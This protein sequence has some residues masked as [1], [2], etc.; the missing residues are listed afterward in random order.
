M[1]L[2]NS[3]ILLIVMAIFLLIS[4]GSVCAN[5]NV[6]EDISLADD[7]TDVV[8]ADGSATQKIDTK[9]DSKNVKINEKETQKIEVTVKDKE[10]KPINVSKE[11]FTVTKDK[12]NLNFT[13]SNNSITLSNKLAKGNHSLLITYLGNDVYNNSTK[14]IVL[15]I[16]GDY[17]I[18]SPSTVNV[19]QTQKVEVP[20]KLTNGVDETKDLSKNK[21][22]VK[23]TYKD[24]NQSKTINTSEL[25]YDKK[26]GKLMFNADL[27]DNIASYTM[28]LTYNNNGT[29]LLKSTTLKKV[30]SI[31]VT[32]IIS[33]NYYQDGNFTFKI[34]DYYTNETIANE[35]ITISGK[36]NGSAI[37]WDIKQ[38]G[39][40]ISVNTAKKLTADSKGIVT[41]KNANFYPNLIL[42][43]TDIYAPVGEY[44]LT[45]SGSDMTC[46]EEVKITIKKVT[47]KISIETF[48]EYYGTSKKIKIV[49][50]NS[51]T[52]KPLSGVTVFFNV[53]DSKGKE[54]VYS[55][56]DSNNTT[57]KVNKI[58]TN[59][60]GAVE[61]PANNLAVGKYSVY[62]LLNSTSYYSKS[63]ATK[64]I[65]IEYSVAYTISQTG[66]VTVKSTS[67]G[68][69]VSGAIVIMKYDNDKNKMFYAQTDKNGKIKITTV[70]KHKLSVSNGDS[71]YSGKT[72]TNTITN[73]KITAKCSAPKVTDYYKGD[74]TFTVKLTNSK[75]SPI[76]DAK[77]KIKIYYTSKRY[78]LY[79]ANTYI[80]GQ[81]RLSLDGLNPGSYKVEI[82][83]GDTKSFN[84]KKVTSKTVIKKSPTKLTPAKLTAK[85][86]ASK[87]FKVT[88]KN[89]KTKKVISGV[90]V[91]IKVY[92]GKKYKTY[93]VKTNSKGIAKLN[94]K[95]LKVGT[96]KV[97]VTSGNKYCVA[98]TAK[99]TIKIT[100]K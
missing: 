62:A 58:S 84:L 21:F 70:G 56:K 90:K 50:V 86:G 7:G 81:L 75:K 37:Y 35:N 91:K 46:N 54:V 77:L 100:K 55:Y 14:S 78:A 39:G 24:G 17:T 41:L 71:R 3:Y 26:A 83:S 69:A 32:P 96:H 15:S 47:S 6:T 13:Y 65:T 31:R 42:T 85:K 68:K 10:S 53:T 95:S 51:E 98:K 63:T 74:K 49:V 20:F 82:T 67:T 73:K 9:I 61:L 16:F 44:A 19:N 79:K 80:D 87:Y 48:N 43:S 5:E 60:N 27:V 29:H 30:R 92:T 2:K 4:I 72:V 23:I 33:E 1:K 64:P 40:S 25:N 8:L 88:V 97:V 52:K 36:N 59:S 34:T 76:Y 11:N 99:S 12:T 57:I 18:D 93:T 28:T 89:T 22:T 94:V 38:S 45:F 66:I